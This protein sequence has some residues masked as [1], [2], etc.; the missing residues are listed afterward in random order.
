MKASAIPLSLRDGS[1]TYT[2]TSEGILEK[3]EDGEVRW[4]LDGEAITSERGEALDA[5]VKRTAITFEYEPGDYTWE[6]PHHGPMPISPGFYDAW[7]RK[8]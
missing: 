6:P 5:T 7:G 2:G 3:R 4:F 8:G 1:I